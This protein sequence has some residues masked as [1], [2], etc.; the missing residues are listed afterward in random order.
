MEGFFLEPPRVGHADPDP[1][2][3]ILPEPGGGDHH[4]RSDFPKIL[5]DGFRRFGKV[6]GKPADEGDPQAP[7][8]VDDPGRRRQRHPVDVLRG[9]EDVEPLKAH[10]DEVPV[11]KH[12]QLGQARGARGEH[13]DG[14][15]VLPAPHDLFFK[16][17]GMV[18]P[19]LFPQEHKIPEADEPGIVPVAVHARGVQVDHLLDQG[20]PVP[21]LQELVH[22]FLVLGEHMGR[23]DA[24]QG[25]GEFRR[26]GGGEKVDRH[27]A[28][29]L[30]GQLG[31]EPLGAI[32]H[33]EPRRVLSS[34]AEGLEPQGDFFDMVPVA[35]PVDGLPDT[36]GLLPDRRRPAPSEGFGLLEENLGKGA[37]PEKG[38]RFFLRS[39]VPVKQPP[40][41]Q[42]SSAGP[43]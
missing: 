4:R 43:R 1:G 6:H 8:L 18:F 29:G 21:D 23:L 9:G 5:G 24:L 25:L 19:I 2:G 28:Q 15:V 3:Q 38:R 30:D 14:D 20:D 7:H 11:G 39:V 33:D 32:V 41:V 36:P 34:K 13:H 10:V 40:H 35:F 27:A 12:G 22:L 37:V 31:E 17:P 26:H 16:D 42:A